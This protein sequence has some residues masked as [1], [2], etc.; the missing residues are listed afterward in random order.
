[1]VVTILEMTTAPESNRCVGRLY[2]RG[3]RGR[4]GRPLPVT[5]TRAAAPVVVVRPEDGRLA[6]EI[7]DTV[8]LDAGVPVR[9]DVIHGLRLG[10]HAGL[11]VSDATS[12]PLTISRSG[13]KRPSPLERRISWWHSRSPS[14][15][16]RI[17]KPSRLDW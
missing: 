1:M 9:P 3:D 6:R 7:L 16:K 15:A 2:R 4:L 12:S 10:P 14:G 11:V 17:W 8:R 5:S 13:D